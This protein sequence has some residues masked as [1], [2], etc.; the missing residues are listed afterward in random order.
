MTTILV[1]GLP[2]SGKTTLS[3]AL[4]KRLQ[5][6]GKT[7]SWFNADTVRTQFD[8]WDFSIE[9][10]IR[11]SQRMRMLCDGSPAE[12][13]ICDFVCPLPEMREIIQADVI[14]CVDTIEK[15]RFED[16]NKCFSF[17]KKMNF[18]ITS[19]DSEYWADIIIK[20]MNENQA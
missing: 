12:Y 9:G 20:T 6:L 16:T 10:R 19:Q 7:A 5:E 15:S 13:N 1:M 17:P 18:H 11:Q 8:D 2:G 3:K 14:V 4:Q